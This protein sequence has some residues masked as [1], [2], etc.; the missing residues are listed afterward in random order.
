MKKRKEWYCYVIQSEK[1]GRSY[2]GCTVN[3]KRRLRQ[4]NGELVGGAKST[5]GRGPWTLVGQAKVKKRGRGEAQRVEKW[6]KRGRGVDGRMKR[7]T[8][9]KKS[10]KIVQK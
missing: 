6:I 10:K 4:H 7:L 2:V 9:Y 8:L 5:R 3:T 1:N